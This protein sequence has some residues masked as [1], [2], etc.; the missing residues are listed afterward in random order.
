VNLSFNELADHIIPVIECG[1]CGE[2]GLASIWT[3]CLPCHQ[4]ANKE[5]RER[6]KARML[7]PAIVIGPGGT[8]NQ[9]V[10]RLK[11]LV[12]DH[13]GNTPMLLH[14]MVMDTDAATFNDQHWSP[15]PELADL[16]R[17][18]LYDPQ[19]P[20]ADVR[21]NAGAY[22]EIREWLPPILD[23]GLLDRQEGSGQI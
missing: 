9:V 11:K 15:L 7:R 4:V 6:L 12:R 8:G 23:V 2:C 17:L 10:R 21:E 3:L 13:Y 16:E 22:P 5:M 14:F 20:F 19:V 1:E 18:P